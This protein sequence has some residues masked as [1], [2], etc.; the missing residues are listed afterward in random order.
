MTSCPDPLALDDEELLGYLL[1]GAV[2]TEDRQRHLEQCPICQRRLS[3]Y[4]DTHLLLSGLYRAHCPDAMKLSLYCEHAL[5]A[6][7]TFA[8][9]EHLRECLLCAEEVSDMRHE[10]AHYTPFPE[11]GGFSLQQVAQQVRRITARLVIQPQAATRQE[12]SPPAWPRYY[13]SP[14]IN[15]SLHL[16]YT[17]THQIVLVGIF[18]CDDEEQTRAYDG[19]AVDLYRLKDERSSIQMTSEGKPTEQPVLSTAVDTLGHFSFAPLQAGD[20]A[21]ILHLPETELVVEQVHLE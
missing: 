17:G 4:K 12:S 16:S 15:L 18:M 13:Q 1:S 3:S 19:T 11:P 9:N 7:E 20:Y 10:L 8:I 5:S 2:P 21:I 6:E 14:A